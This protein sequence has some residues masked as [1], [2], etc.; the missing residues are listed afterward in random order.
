MVPTRVVHFV[1]IRRKASFDRFPFTFTVDFPVGFPLG[2]GL[3]SGPTGDAE[4]RADS[5]VVSADKL[6][7]VIE[8]VQKIVQRG[9]RPVAH[10]PIE[11]GEP[12]YA[13][14]ASQGFDLVVRL[15]PWVIAYCFAVGVGI[16]NRLTGHFDRVQR[17]LIAGVPYVND[18]SQ[19]VHALDHVDTEIA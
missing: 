16:D 6:C 10:E 18:H 1:D 13:T 3:P 17:A 14:L 4:V 12:Y 8:M 11:A 19:F 5:Y 15:V 9:T 7:Y 2:I